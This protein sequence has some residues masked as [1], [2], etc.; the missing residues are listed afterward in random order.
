MEIIPSQASHWPVNYSSAFQ[1]AK[2]IRGKLHFGTVAV[3]AVALVPFCAALC[4]W[5]DDIDEFRGAYF[6]HELRGYKGE[7]SHIEDE[8]GRNLEEAFDTF[9][10]N[11][12]MSRVDA[13]N[14]LVDV[15][16]EIYDPTRVVLWSKSAH[17]AILAYILPSLDSEQIHKLQNRRT[18]LLDN[19]AQLDDFAGF[20]CEPGQWGSQNGV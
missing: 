17:A 19:V 4:A 10:D 20:R 13:D 8:D 16:L 14:W 12:D 1:Q 5:L 6:A 2:D 7:T 3:P 11:I 18:F 15:G 9:F